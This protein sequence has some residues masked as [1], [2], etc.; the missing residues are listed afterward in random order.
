MTTVSWK[1]EPDEHDYPAASDYLELLAPGDQIAAIESAL[2]NAPI[3]HK[4]AKD[5]LRASRLPLLPTENPHV[6]SDLGKIAKGKPLSPI[7]AVR[8]NL[9]GGVALQIADG[10]HRVCASYHTDENTDIPVK[11]VLLGQ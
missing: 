5:L 11:I 1:T 7:L 10:Y 8:G 6:Q 9:A 3:V 2:R 4:K